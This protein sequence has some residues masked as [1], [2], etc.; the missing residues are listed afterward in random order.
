MTQV[1]LETLR[2]DIE[3][4]VS[5]RDSSTFHYIVE[6]LAGLLEFHK[7][8]E[9][10]EVD[11]WEGRPV[12]FTSKTELK[13]FVKT[14]LFRD[15]VYR[16][17]YVRKNDF[18]ISTTH[19]LNPELLEKGVYAARSITSNSILGLEHKI[20]P[21]D[22]INE[23]FQPREGRDSL[24]LALEAGYL[25]KYHELYFLHPKFLYTLVEKKFRTKK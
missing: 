17:K 4:L 11:S 23:K 15:Y 18:L 21:I 16:K 6:R 13:S 25:I 24:A 1:D 20:L 7:E 12:K 22:D 9:W 3:S 14:F 8:E 5:D 19:H 2:R 10:Y